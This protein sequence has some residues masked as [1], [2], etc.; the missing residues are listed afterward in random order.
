MIVAGGGLAGLT[1][2]GTAAQNG[3]RVLMLE[4]HGPGGRARTVEPGGLHP[5]HGCARASTSE[6][7][8]SGCSAHAASTPAGA[9]PPLRRYR[10]LT[11]GAQH[12]LPTGPG[13]LARTRAVGPRSKAQLLA[14][15]GRV[16][17]IRPATLA[18]TSVADWLASHRLRPDA[19]AV[20]R[21]LIRLSTYTADVDEFSAD[22]AVAQLQLAA[23]GGVLYLHGGWSQLVDAL[24]REID[25]R[26]GTEATGVDRVGDHVE[27]QTREGTLVAH[28]VVVATGAP[29]SGAAGAAGRP[30]VG[31]ART[32]GDRGV[33]RPRGQPGSRARLRPL[34]R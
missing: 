21:A 14:L 18:T 28:R 4:A 20:V 23:K 16:P 34:A 2:A 26:T 25:I 33:P 3:A 17:R 31:G 30:G 8:D 11:A 10:A 27:V 5:Q 12:L 13:S 7:P 29:D 24:G 6:E 9:A 32:A 22:A 15:L 1:A 19:E